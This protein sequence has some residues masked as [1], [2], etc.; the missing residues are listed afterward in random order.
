MKIVRIGA[1]VIVLSFLLI[2][3]AV[4]DNEPLETSML[5]AVED[6]KNQPETAD[7]PI[8]VVEENTD[9]SMEPLLLAQEYMCGDMSLSICT[10]W[11]YNC[12]V[13]SPTSGSTGCD[14]NWTEENCG[15]CCSG[16]GYW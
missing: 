5:A 3:P 9:Q 8:N 15:N 14:T 16:C 1:L 11:F 7:M 4:A 6:A 10:Y 2:G 12:C 13:S